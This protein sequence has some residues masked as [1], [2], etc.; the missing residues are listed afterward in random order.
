LAKILA[1]AQF[2]LAFS[3]MKFCVAMVSGVRI[4]T[5]VWADGAMLPGIPQQCERTEEKVTEIINFLCHLIKKCV[6]FVTSGV[7]VLSL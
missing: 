3:D 5:W 7:L 1:A 2:F 6:L 4:V